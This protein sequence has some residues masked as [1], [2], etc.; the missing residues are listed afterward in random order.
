MKIIAYY[1]PQFH[2]IPENDA[3]WGEGFTEW[4]NVK[5]AKPLFDG[6]NQPRIPQDN[7]YYN[8]LQVDIIRWQAELAKKNHIWG[9]CFYHYWFGEKILL[10]KPMEILLTNKDID[11]PFCISWANENWTN[12][13]V[14][15]SPKLLVKQEYGDEKEWARHFDYLLPFFK[16][17]RYIKENGKPVVVIYKPTNFN[18]INDMKDFWNNLAIANRFKGICFMS[19]ISNEASEK[20]S[21][22]EKIDYI[23]DYQPTTIFVDKSK[24][25]NV[26]IRK[27]KH[28]IKKL[29]R[30]FNIE[31]EGKKIGAKL[32][33]YDYSDIW[34][35]VLKRQPVSE[36]NV[37]GC[38]VDWDNTPRKGNKGTVLLNASPGKFKQFFKEQV[39]RCKNLYKKDF[40]FIFAWNEWAEGGYLEPDK[41]YHDGYLKAIRATLEELDEVPENTSQL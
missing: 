5:G 27:T 25:R 14:S 24:T 8:L 22:F 36:K 26:F 23:L 16:D 10:Q 35:Q 21:S 20:K 38:F 15:N 31:L 37:P 17:A 3:W 19:Q 2:C 33:M 39:I 7:N 32:V 13:W 12:Q 6:H 11:I 40:M 34:Q 9:F 4:V 30:V 29:M 28:L 18:R 41:H 1:L